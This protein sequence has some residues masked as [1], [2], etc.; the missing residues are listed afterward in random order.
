MRAAQYSAPD[1]APRNTAPAT[2][3][4]IILSAQSGALKE[5]FAFS[6]MALFI[7]AA[8]VCLPG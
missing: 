7:V 3:Q 5:C 6:A 2:V 4:A 1:C 8:A